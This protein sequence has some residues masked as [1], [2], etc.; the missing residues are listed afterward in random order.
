MINDEKTARLFN[1][2]RRVFLSGCRCGLPA[3]QAVHGAYRCRP[4][5]VPDYLIP[6][7][8]MLPLY[9]PCE[10]VRKGGIFD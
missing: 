7:N 8:Q 9:F 4:N 3:M 10:S 6:I 1:G 2:R 5:A